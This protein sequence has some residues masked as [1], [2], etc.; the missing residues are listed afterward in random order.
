MT[1]EILRLKKF[2]SYGVVA[3]PKV[4]LQWQEGSAPPKK[5]ILVAVLGAIPE[6]M[7]IN[8]AFITKRM[9]FLGWVPAPPEPPTNE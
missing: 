1:G 2:R 9:E 5:H 8:E 6:D 7:Q 4:G 3:R